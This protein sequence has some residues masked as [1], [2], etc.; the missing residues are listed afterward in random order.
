MESLGGNED[1]RHGHY[2]HEER[3]KERDDI[4]IALEEVSARQSCSRQRRSICRGL[5]AA[6][7]RGSI[8]RGL[9]AAEIRGRS[10]REIATVEIDGSG[11][12]GEDSEGLIRPGEIAPDDVEINKRHTKDDS[13]HRNRDNESF[14]DG[15]L[16][17]M[18]E[19]GHDESC[20]SQ[21]RIT[22]GDRC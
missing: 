10:C 13:K 16:L 7:I 3:R 22:R 4:T 14:P 15:S 11:P 20:T 18:E 1:I 19:I 5:G 17:Q 6:E 21:C 9:G 12:E 2:S 8:C